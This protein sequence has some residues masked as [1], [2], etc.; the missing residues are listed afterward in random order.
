V[1]Q[2]VHMSQ[3]RG[4]ALAMHY[5]TRYMDGGRTI[6]Q[7]VDRVIQDIDAQSLDVLSHYISGDVAR[8][9]GLELAAAINRLRTLKMKQE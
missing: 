9:R 4:I 2:I 5:A 8:F 6:K 3:T 7:V 1:E